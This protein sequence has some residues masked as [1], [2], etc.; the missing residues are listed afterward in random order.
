MADL[1]QLT[2]EQQA[3]FREIMA[4]SRRQLFQLQ[5]EQSPKIQAI[6]HETNRKLIAILN[7]DQQRKFESFVKEMEN[8]RRR[9]PNGFQFGQSMRS[10]QTPVDGRNR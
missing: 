9:R 7:E 5:L 2:P 10:M 8:R 6:R 4:E 1:L 3:R